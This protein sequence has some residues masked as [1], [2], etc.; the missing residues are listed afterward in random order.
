MM[1]NIAACRRSGGSKEENIEA[2]VQP[3]LSRGPGK[4]AAWIVLAAGIAFSVAA[5]FFAESVAERDASFKF[6]SATAAIAANAQARMHSY[7]DLLRGLQ[8]VFQADPALSR[9]A[10][11]R[12]VY[13]LDLP[14]HYPGV[15]AVSYAR[16]VS[17][18]EREKFEKQLRLD[19]ELIRRGVRDV[20][21]NP[22]GERSDYLV[23]TYIEPLHAN[24]SALG[25]DLVADDSRMAVIERARDTGMPSLSGRV[26]LEAD[27]TRSEPALVMRLALY[28]K[29]AF[30][31]DVEGRRNAYVGMAN[32]TFMVRELGQHIISGEDYGKFSLSIRDAGYIDSGPNWQGETLYVYTASSAPDAGAT[33]ENSRFVDVGQR[34]WE[35]KFSAPKELFMRA[36]DRV[37]PWVALAAMLTI[38]LLLSG[39]IHFLTG[40]RERATALAMRMTDEL[41]QSQA[42]LTEEKRRTQE[43]IEVLPNPIYFKGTDGRYLGVNRAWETYF[44]RSR[45]DFLGKTVHELYPNDP[46]VAQ[47]LHADDQRVWDHPGSHSYETTITAGDGNRHDVIYYKAP[48]AGADGDVS[49]LIGTIVDITGRRRAENALRE[50]EIQLRGILGSTLDGILAVDRDGK[51]I[52]MNQ[53]FAQLWRIPQAVLDS[54]DDKTLIDHVVGQLADPEAFVKRIQALYQSDA[55]ATDT[56]DFK[57]GRTFERF[58]SPLIL[59]Q[60]IVGRVWS[61][62]DITERKQAEV[63]L[64]LSASV[65]THAREGILITD[66]EGNI[67][68][69]NE[70]FSH[71][72]GY[73][74][75]EVLGRNPRLLQSGRQNREFYA[76][77]WRDLIEKGH[78]LGELWNRRKTGELYAEMLTISAVRDEQGTTH[79]YVALFSDITSLKEH[80]RQLEHIAHYD[81]LTALPNR[82]L[83]ADRL[84]QA[85]AQVQRR[86]QSLAVAYLDL[87]GFKPIN[88]NHGHSAGDQML[89]AIAT[90]MKQALREGDTLAR[91]G[92][93][94]FV[95]VLLDLADIKSSEPMLTRL[96]AAAAQPQ[97]VGDLMLQVSASLGVTFFPQTE[98]V[99]ADQL[100]RQADQ[101]M[102]QA[103]LAGKNRYHV[104]DAEL[105]RSVR[106]HHESLERVRQA[107]TER[108]LVL[109]Y[110]PKVNMR[111]GTVIGAEA[112]IRWRHPERG[113][114]LPAVFL[115]VI[116][117]HALAV[118]VGEW[119]IEAALTQM[120]IWQAAGLKLPVSVNVGALQ[121][122]KD[123]FV[124]RLRQ[125]LAAHPNVKLGELELEVVET[126]ALED[127]AR[128]SEIIR[129]CREMGVRF[130][131]DDFGTGYSSLTYLKHLPITLLKIDQS[132]VHDMLDDPDDLA[133][134]QGVLGLAKA[135][136]REV[137]AEGVET[138]EHGMLLLQL[139]CELA[140]G[141]GI[142]HPMPAHEMPSWAAAW[143]PNSAWLNLRPANHEDLPL[144][145][146]GAEH[147]AWV[148]AI[149]EH[150]KDE[151]QIPPPLDHHQCH[152]GIWL[153]DEGQRRYGAQ[154]AF[155]AMERLHRKVHALVAEMCDL[156]SRGRNLDALERTVRL[157]DLRDA[158]IEQLKLL[159]KEVRQ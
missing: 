85:I 42:S 28:R 89:I 68:E 114:L 109:Y 83:L 67:I 74:R 119:V 17:A 18:T 79:Q 33:F 138:M 63:R 81:A 128:V 32:L 77:M 1:P 4:L 146:A 142:A 136:R 58:T 27:P 15:R 131:L 7:S 41:R 105:D 96:L 102:Y 49:G 31:P 19:P 151:R 35:L 72:T 11:E 152:L 111:T 158:L 88:D 54:K 25:L 75:D 3:A 130:A 55:E 137:I 116:E 98:D 125:I 135:F 9:A 118:E 6:Q 103:K 16:R 52:Q 123:D 14:L 71:I 129:A 95:A 62:R 120:E 30:T 115:P 113:L 139:G 36:A 91:L 140:Q 47:R 22:P 150:L 157:H 154:P 8:G 133:I 70:A 76:A 159:E 66:A 107:L 90:R 64:Q 92:G 117:D 104:F 20:V 94:E 50:N 82:V 73:S 149:E 37:L 69:V 2:L 43:L 156:H 13:S 112:L 5:W 155:K 106:G 51:V 144:L 60:S 78:W 108:E 127:L 122:Q 12:Y 57:D 153:D 99:D 132:F 148:R 48:F 40:S 23:I 134:L 147:R 86:G 143:R 53:R 121:L 110:Q 84:Q 38:S 126:T 101:A 100:L 80:E 61:F 45:Q 124:E 56:I 59:N 97:R 93:D 46:E 87:D 44:G 65:F 21:I 29:D 34:R 10:F 145:F 26:V 39:L 141:Y 24:R